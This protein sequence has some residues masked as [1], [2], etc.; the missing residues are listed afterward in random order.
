[1]P[2]PDEEPALT[3]RV[4]L[5]KLG[6]LPATGRRWR[7]RRYR[8]FVARHAVRDDE[9]AEHYYDKIYSEAILYAQSVETRLA[10]LVGA[11][12]A[13]RILLAESRRARAPFRIALLSWALTTWS[14]G[15]F[16]FSVTGVLN[17][18]AGLVL[19]LV[20][21]GTGRWRARRVINGFRERR[22]S[23]LCGVLDTLTPSGRRRALR[24]GAEFP[25]QVLL[26]RCGQIILE[27]IGADPATVETALLLAEEFDGTITELLDTA[28]CLN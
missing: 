1:M 8:A 26:E 6:G 16:V 11:G 23:S 21:T 25:A 17:G 12:R 4:L 9:A 22:G 24:R 15:L 5:R 14:L 3:S 28:R 27:R 19:L 10:C 18:A 20:G 13:E 2:Q 7:M